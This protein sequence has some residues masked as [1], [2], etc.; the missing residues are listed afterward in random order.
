MRTSNLCDEFGVTARCLYTELGLE[1]ECNITLMQNKT[2][3]QCLFPPIILARAQYPKF[4]P[5]EKRHLSQP[6]DTAGERL[7]ESCESAVRRR[8]LPNK[9]PASAGREGGRG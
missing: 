6:L 9:Q 5:G 2:V 1:E 4:I 7:R 8:A 3:F